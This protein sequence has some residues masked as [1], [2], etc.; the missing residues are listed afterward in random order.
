MKAS[1]I[2]AKFPFPFG[3]GAPGANVR[4]LP[5]TTADPNAASVTLGFPTNTLTPISAGGSPPDGR[6]MN[7]ILRQDTAWANWQGLGGTVGYDAAASAAALPTPGYPAGAIVSAAVTVSRG[8]GFFWLCL[9]DDNVT[10]PETGGAGWQAFSLQGFDVGDVK[11]TYNDTPPPGWVAMNDGSIGDA[12]SG[13]TNLQSPLALALFTLLYRTVTDAFAPIQTSAGAATTRAAQGTAAAAW[14]AKC[15]LGLPKALGRAMCAA[16]TGAGLTARALGTALGEE[17]HQLTV[18]ELA[19]HA[20]PA[21]V[22]DP[23]HVHTVNAVPNNPALAAGGPTQFAG[24]STATITTTAAATGVRV[25][26]GS[27]F[28]TTNPAGSN[29]PH[30]NMPPSTFLN[31]WAH[32]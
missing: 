22:F 7:G 5:T 32:L 19:S 28:D 1:D 31:F 3:T 17:T 4:P 13:A 20:H 30:N 23:T 29:V 25:W 27:S 8:V 9:V 26:D 24:G 21:F 18:A 10:N 12:G 11:A 14:N 2:P 16:G 6:D 15:R